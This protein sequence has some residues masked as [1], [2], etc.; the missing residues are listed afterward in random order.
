MKKIIILLIIT[1][2]LLSCS[3]EKKVTEKISPMV[4][5]EEREEKVS[6]DLIKIKDNWE[7]IT[8]WEKGLHYKS[9]NED[10]FIWPEF[11]NL[12]LW[13]FKKDISMP[14]KDELPKVTVNKEI[15][16]EIENELQKLDKIMDK[17]EISWDRREDLAIKV[18]EK[19]IE[20]Q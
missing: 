9:E 6:N 14:E 3:T 7:E 8:I 16:I 12:I 2:W 4:I 19:I 20:K 15:M 11:M 1:F 10:I 13:E 18:I 17:Y 5:P